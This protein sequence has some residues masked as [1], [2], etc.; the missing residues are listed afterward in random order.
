MSCNP[1]L[2]SYQCYILIGLWTLLVLSLLEGLLEKCTKISMPFRTLK[3][4]NEYLTWGNPKT[5]VS[6]KDLP[7][8]A[9]VPELPK[10]LEV[11]TVAPM[12]VGTTTEVPLSL[13]SL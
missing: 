4:E 6:D 8:K 11:I 2:H 13:P 3:E 1:L 5:T 7:L 12:T 9:I 10:S